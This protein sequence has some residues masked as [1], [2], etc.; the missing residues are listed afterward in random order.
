MSSMRGWRAA[1]ACAGAIVVAAMATWVAVGRAPAGAAGHAQQPRPNVVVIMSDDQTVEQQ[2]ALEHVRTQ[3]ALEGTTF[4]RNYAVYPLC[5]PSRSTYVTGQYPHNHGVLGNKPPEGG[6]YKLDSANTLPVWMNG[7]GYATAHFGKYLNGYGTRDPKEV[8]PGWQNWQGAVDPTTYNYLRYCL[9]ENGT[10]VGYGTSPAIQKA[11]PGAV[12][13]PAQY[14]TDLYT[15]KAVDYIDA[16]A[17][18]AQPFFLS[19]A[20][21]APHSGG[22]N[23]PNGRCRGSAKPPARHRGAFAGAILPRPPG[24]NEPDV[25]DKPPFIRRLP[26]LGRA[27]IENIARDYRCRREALLAVDDG[28][29]RIMAALQRSGELGNTLVIFTSDNGFFQGEH[30][31]PRGKIKVYEPSTRVPAVMRGP[32]VPAGRR[33][34]AL[35]A[36]IDLAATVADVAGATPGRVLDGVSLRAIAQRPRQ[37]AGR[38]LVLETGPANGPANPQY[39]AL[40]TGRW[41]YVEYVTGPRELYDLRADPFE[42][43]NVYAVKR[44]TAKG[45]AAQLAR[46]RT[47]AGEACR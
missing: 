4:A 2:Q 1:G 45:L 23:P 44:E 28:V 15:A 30:R 40:R 13:R 17:P 21:L 31:V 8:P 33:V 43:R 10:L 19:V 47:C 14:Q 38:R 42:R 25:S 9:N 5:C 27:G 35:T 37:F 3:I 46:L 34:N 18:N 29:Q 41:K 6:Y 11:C 32:G 20:Y 12:Q 16:M 26:R 36:N 24:F 22:P 7:A 39:S